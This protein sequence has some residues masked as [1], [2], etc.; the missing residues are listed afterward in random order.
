MIRAANH[1]DLETIVHLAGLK[2][3]RY[4]AWQPV[5]HKRAH[6]AEKTHHVYLAGQI[7]QPNVLFLVSEEAG[8]VNGFLLGA[9]V[10]APPVYAPG[11][12][13]L[14]VDDFTVEPE[15]LWPSAGKAL[16]VEAQ[17]EAKK[18]G[19]V[20]VNVVCGPKDAPKREM[21]LGLGLSVASE[22]L[23]KPLA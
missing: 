15:T 12:I 8:K 17:A 22:W 21:L 20:L 3:A 4:E 14:M 1:S 11:G 9:L 5:F 19:S 2:R 6:D 16:L 13:V 23:V 10:G 7:G 18:R